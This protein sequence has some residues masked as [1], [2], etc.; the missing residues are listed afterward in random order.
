MYFGERFHGRLVPIIGY[1]SIY[2]FKSLDH[3]REHQ[4]GHPEMGKPRSV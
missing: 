3:S 4:E 2:S 1:D